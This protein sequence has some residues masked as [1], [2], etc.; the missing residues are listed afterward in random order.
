M[1]HSHAQRRP[2]RGLLQARIAL[3]AG[4]HQAAAGHLRAP[5]LGELTPRC[6]LVR[7]LPLAAAAIGRGD[8]RG[9]GGILARALGAARRE[10]F[11]DT[12]V[13]TA[14]AVTGY[15]IEHAAQMHPDPFTEQLIASAVQARAAQPG[16]SRP[17]G[18]P[19]R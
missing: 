2:A 11:L 7:Q 18:R 16:S 15:L 5:S 9:A 6:E 8:A 19:S 10:G 17:A 3:A 1:R 13:T 4:D 12:V 14:P